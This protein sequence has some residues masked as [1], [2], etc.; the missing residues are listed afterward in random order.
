[1]PLWLWIVIIVLVA[2]IV[3]AAIAWFETRRRRTR[4]LRKEFGPEYEHAVS[5]HG[6]RGRA[7]DELEARRKRVEQLQIH[8]LAPEER[9][10]FSEQWHAAQAHFVDEPSRAIA[11]ADTLVRQAMQAR[12]YPVGDFEQRAADVSV[13]HPTVVREYRQAHAASV[14]NERGE[15]TTEDLRQAMVHYRALFDDLLAA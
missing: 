1:M 3:I 9:Q 5:A 10:R 15:A 2:L 4:E 13:D 14:R 11:E 7:E 8:P 12:G 6:D